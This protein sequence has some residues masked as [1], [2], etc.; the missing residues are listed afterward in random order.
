MGFDD[1]KGTGFEEVNANDSFEGK[2]YGWDDEIEK[3]SEGFTLL[4]PGEYDFEVVNFERARHN[5][6]A[7]LPACNKAIITLRVSAPDGR[8]VDL[9]HNLF[10]HSKCEGLLSAFFVGIGLKKHGE[11]L[12]MD[13]SKVVG[14]RGRCTVGVHEYNGKTYN[15]IKRILEPKEAPAQTSF[16]AGTF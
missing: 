9:K 16:K 3:D 10:L 4:E 12:K 15:D 2:E 6:S 5:G 14:R 11:K 7:K 8:S 13:W 1:I